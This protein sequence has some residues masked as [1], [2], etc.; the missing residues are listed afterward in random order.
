VFERRIIAVEGEVQGVGFRPFIYNLALRLGASGYVANTSR[1]VT[2]EVQAEARVLDRFQAAVVA[3][4]PPMA[5]PRI[6]SADSARVV[7]AERAFTIRPS[8]DGGLRRV[9][10]TPDAATCADCVRELG[11]PGNRR[12]RYPFINCTNCGPRYTIV[13]DV[14]YDRPNTTMRVFE[15]CPECRAEYEDPTDRRFHAQPNACPKCGPRVF[16]AGADGGSIDSDDPVREVVRLLEGGAI[17]AVK[18]LGGVHL[19][20]RADSADGVRELRRRKYRK[21]KAFAVMVRDLAAA[22]ALAQVD[23]AAEALLAGVERPIVL[24]PKK[25]GAILH[26]LVAPNSRFWGIMLPYTPLHA[27]LMQ[28]S[29][30]ALVMT[31]GN[32]SDEPIEHENESALRRL[33]GIADIFLL[34]NRG[35]YTSCDDSVVKTFRGAPLMIRRARGYV[36]RPVSLERR[37]DGDILAVGAELKNNVT[38]L[39]GERAFISQHIGDLAGAATY[40]SFQRTVEKLGAL[41]GARPRGVACD[42]H[43]AM[44]STRFAESY[45]EVPIIR[46]QHHHAHIASVMGEHDVEGPVAGIAADGVGYG[47]DGA[48]WGCEGLVAWRD[49][50]ERRASLAPVPMPGGD[51]ASREGWRMAVSYL[52][53]IVPRQ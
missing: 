8:T 26:D 10:I 27:L 21:A 31:S 7:E 47:T 36:P 33:G 20:V 30:P 13:S 25:D 28:G 4:H 51:A 3:E 53:S 6:V 39:K 35:I 29:Y 45:K 5:R 11:D 42:M 15:M 52:I 48:V 43:P 37:A 34:H 23:S 12:F 32:N 49:R 17:V 41:V 19:A 50:F 16:L 44:L 18:G 1:G 22:Q 2:I 9:A 46:V 14:P 38:F 40:E 24:C